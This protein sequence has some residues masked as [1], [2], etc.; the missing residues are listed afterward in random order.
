VTE[1]TSEP[2]PQHV[3][4]RILARVAERRVP[5]V[6]AEAD[7]L[8]QV[9]VEPKRT[10]DDARDRRRLQRVRHARADVIAARVDEDLRLPLQASEGLR[11]HEAVAVALELGAHGA[12]L[13][14]TLPPP[15]LERP[16]G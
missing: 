1:A 15:C 5:G 14:R 2:V 3:V 9:L 16:D 10:R 7:R 6:V 12:W 11:V 4:E 13:F 8:G